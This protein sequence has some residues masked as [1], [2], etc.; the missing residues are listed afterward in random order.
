MEAEA[1]QVQIRW[2]RILFGFHVLIWLIARLVVGSLSVMPPLA[3][4]QD[5]ESWG[6]LVALHGLVLAILDGRDQARVPSWVNHLIETRERRWSLLAIDMALVISLTIAMANRIIPYEIIERYAVPLSLLWLVLVG[7]GYTQILLTIYAEVRD[8]TAHKR[9]YVE[10]RKPEL[11]FD[12]LAAS[13]DDGELIDFPE[14]N[15][16]KTQ[17]D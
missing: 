7:F 9:K 2:R 1:K 3:L 8:R 11:A 10:K 15:Q 5:F 4:Y 17:Q 16:Y 12:A 14:P 6:A 13:A